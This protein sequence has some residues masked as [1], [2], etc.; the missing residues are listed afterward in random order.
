MFTALIAVLGCQPLPQPFQPS[1]AKKISN[2]LVDI[3]DRSG[4][5]VRPVT[6]MPGEPGAALARA[7]AAALIERNLPAFTENGNRSSLVLTGNAI[8]RTR[9][10]ARSEIRLIWRVSDPDGLQTGEHVIDIAARKSAW[11]KGSPNLLREMASKSAGKIAG[12]IQGPA[13]TDLTLNKRK[14]TLHVWP[15]DGAPK[16]AAA[17]LRAELETSLRRRALRVSSRMR[18]D[19]I[20]IVGVVLLSPGPKGQRQLGIEWSVM[21]PDGR[22]L[23]KLNQKNAVSPKN[24]ENDWPKI[25]RNIATG[26]A[27][28]IGE[29]LNKVPESAISDA[30]TPIN[31]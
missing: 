6:G 4:D 30:P 8:A 27:E 12:I 13:V 19:S 17:L 28:G 22:E 10:A 7:M 11:M 18:D 26:A 15:I 31:R 25:A 29:M 24:L 1:D 3:P 5:G 21:S 14:R 16:T 20:V 2:P 9:G 23:G